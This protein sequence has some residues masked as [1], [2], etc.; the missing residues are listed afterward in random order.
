MFWVT[1]SPLVRQTWVINQLSYFGLR[2]G[3][4][5]Q[6]QDWTACSRNFFCCHS[7][8]HR[9]FR[10]GEA[11]LISAGP[12]N[13]PV[14]QHISYWKILWWCPTSDVIL[15]LLWNMPLKMTHVHHWCSMCSCCGLKQSSTCLHRRIYPSLNSCFISNCWFYFKRC[16]QADGFTS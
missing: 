1:M 10:S 11:S 12:R 8:Q 2:L 5:K 3:L 16:L 14:P 9:V 4:A 6:T 15:N 13:P 7:A